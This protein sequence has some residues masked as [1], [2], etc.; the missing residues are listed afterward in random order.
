M[1]LLEWLEKIEAFH[2]DEIELGL[3]RVSRLAIELN[4]LDSSAKIITVG[5][6]NGKGSTVATLE[7]LALQSGLTVGCYTSPHLLRFN[8]RIRINGTDIDDETVVESFEIIEASRQLFSEKFGKPL[9]ITF[10][11]FTTLAALIIFK[12]T[13]LDL[14]VLEVGLGG[15]L[16]AVNILN[17]EVAI[18]TTIAKDHQSW[19]GNDL[20]TIAFEKSGIFRQGVLNYVGDQSSLD[21]ILQTRPEFE[22]NLFLPSNDV[23]DTLTPL[24]ADRRINPRRLLKQNLSL[25][26]F[27]FKSLFPNEFE[28]IDLSNIIKNIQLRGRFQVVCEQPLTILDV[29]HNEQSA[30]NLV[31]QL[32]MLPL[33]GRRFAIC[34]MMEDKSISEFL[35]AL[36]K[37]IDE[38]KFVNLPIVRA[39]SAAELVSIGQGASLKGGI[40]MHESVVSAWRAVESVIEEGD[41][42]LI[43][44]SFI[45]VAEGIVAIK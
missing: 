25:A 10:F 14:V 17:P 12:R 9:A 26:I 27:A 32:N 4:L 28:N 15:R 2:P 22:S 24:I 8:E 44:G 11:E 43:L 45:T 21:L 31:L 6:T 39:A 18:V 38:W 33:L 7:S 41:Q 23:V 20:K 1:N 29:A 42:L 37:A 3:E 34:G 16:D 5:G 13:E 40:Q 30:K 35:L 36:D 19:L